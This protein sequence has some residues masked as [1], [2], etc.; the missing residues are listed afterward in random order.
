MIDV[1]Y[2]LRNCFFKAQRFGEWI[3]FHNQ[4]VKAGRI[5]FLP[6]K[7]TRVG[8]TNSFLIMCLVYDLSGTLC[9]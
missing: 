9:Y 6:T 7:V 3:C 5:P 1:L 8:N 4:E 2:H